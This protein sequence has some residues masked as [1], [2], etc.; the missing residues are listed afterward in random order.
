MTANSRSRALAI[1]GS[2]LAALG[3]CLL[4]WPIVLEGR[5]SGAGQLRNGA[6]AAGALWTGALILGRF[7]RG[8]RAGVALGFVRWLALPAGI[9]LG[10]GWYLTMNSGSKE[11][12]YRAAMQADLRNLM[13]AEEAFRSD[14]GRY[15]S[16]LKTLD[17]FPSSGVLGPKLTLTPNGFQAAVTHTNTNA[18][19]TVVMGQAGR[20]MA[21]KN[22]PECDPAPHSYKWLALVLLGGGLVL[23]ALAIGLATAPA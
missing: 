6:I 5:I 13:L 10:F 14:S 2:L 3:L 22:E 9:L 17:W 7:W 1:A 12:A 11:Y 15:S 20:A 18:T 23:G 21:G 16:D 19:C 4:H 8:A